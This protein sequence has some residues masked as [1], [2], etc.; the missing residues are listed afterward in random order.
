MT[1]YSNI[2]E[3]IEFSRTHNHSAT[4]ET[5]LTTID[6]V[7]DSIGET[8]DGDV[9]YAKIDANT[10]DVWG[11]SGECGDGDMDWRLTVVLA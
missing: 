3:A 10:Y 5:D 4:V 9:D 11:Y 7:I 2:S 1:T 8:Y 6:A